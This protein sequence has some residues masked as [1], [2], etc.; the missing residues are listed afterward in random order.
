MTPEQL[1]QAFKDRGIEPDDVRDGAH[2]AAHALAWNVTTPW[3][4]E[5]IAA[6]AP[7]DNEQ[8]FQEEIIARAVEQIVCE[9]VGAPCEPFPKR[10]LIAAMEAVKIDRYRVDFE[11][12]IKSIENMLKSEEAK[13]LAL[14]VLALAQEPSRSQTMTTPTPTWDQDPDAALR[15]I[16]REFLSG[17]NYTRRVAYRSALLRLRA[18][19]KDGQPLPEPVALDAH[20]KLTFD[21]RFIRVVGPS[22]IK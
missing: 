19:A 21:G 18:L 5:R 22:T 2:E 15:V 12:W 9:A 20:R 1:L 3:T 10:A 14:Q 13:A 17:G 6:A 7:R 16:A 11:T 4:R 8:K